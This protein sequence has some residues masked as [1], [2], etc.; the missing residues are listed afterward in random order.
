MHCRTSKCTAQYSVSNERRVLEVQ[1]GSA[2]RVWRQTDAAFYC[3]ACGGKSAHTPREDLR[4]YMSF[5]G[6]SHESVFLFKPGGRVTKVYLGVSWLS[7]YVQSV[8]K[9]ATG[10][11]ILTAP[12]VFFFSK[13]Q[14]ARCVGTGIGTMSVLSSTAVMLQYR[15]NTQRS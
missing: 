12:V 8:C 5:S 13:M 10:V 3:L 15:S 7:T 6:V 1:L 2:L 9:V 11:K 14:P 4:F